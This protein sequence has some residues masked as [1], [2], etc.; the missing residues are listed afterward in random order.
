MDFLPT[1][2]HARILA[3]LPTPE[4]IA[5][6]DCVGMFN[7]TAPSATR[8][9]LA[10]RAGTQAIPSDASTQ[11]LL[12]A[13]MQRRAQR[14]SAA[15]AVYHCAFV[16]VEGRLMVCGQERCRG[17]QDDVPQD[18]VSAGLL[19]LGGKTHACVSV[20]SHRCAPHVC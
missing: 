5:C 18:D 14:D 11:E 12:L 1:E 15:A 13:E 16:S 7:R 10:L 8:M 19:G 2:L 20:R 9:A 3:Y 6:A 4:D 17:P